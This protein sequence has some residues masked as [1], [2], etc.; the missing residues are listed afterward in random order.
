MKARSYQIT[1]LL[2]QIQKDF[3]VVLFYGTDEGEIQHAFSVLK[4]EFNFSKEALHFITL[5]K[6]DL[7]KSPFLAT[8]EANSISLI[9]GKK[10]LYVPEDASFS[11]QSLN[12]FLQNKK[13]DALL[14]IKAGNL[15]KSNSLRVEAEKNPRVLAL[16]CYEP[17]EAEVQKMVTNYL[18]EYKKS[19]PSNLLSIL[20][21][22]IG[23]NQQVI[24]QELDK[25]ILYMGDKT[26]VDLNMIQSCLTDSA[27]PNEENF[28]IA[29]ADGNVTE[30]E[31]ALSYFADQ[32]NSLTSLLWI[33]RDYFERLLKIVSD[34]SEP[35]PQIVKKNLRPAQFRLEV[36]LIRQAK[37]WASND[38]LK[39]MDRLSLLEKNSRT[40][41][42]PEITISA[43]T[44]LDIALFAKKLR[45]LR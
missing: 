33:I 23:L 40:T 22:K 25:L 38:I 27:Q 15:T 39:V 34:T 5:S 4:K 24:V 41:G 11:V 37:T 9:Q 36:P 29:L 31:K 20:V 43:K 2:S 32:E 21:Q 28:C 13:T 35:V 1:A 18:R 42:Y 14:I 16:A 3:D 26:T 17:T 7:K 30:V 19:I 45:S 44:L 8:D 6:D 10:Y 12:H